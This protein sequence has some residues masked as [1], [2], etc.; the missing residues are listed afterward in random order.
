MT[1]H[2]VY[3]TTYPEC[4]VRDCW[5]DLTQYANASAY[6]AFIMHIWHR[7]QSNSWIDW[8]IWQIQFG[9]SLIIQQI[10]QSFV[11][12]HKHLTFIKLH[13]YPYLE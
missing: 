3:T 12:T 11:N 6:Y 8:S 1:V 4:S 5:Y 10:C 7:F 9:Q 2:D 13:A